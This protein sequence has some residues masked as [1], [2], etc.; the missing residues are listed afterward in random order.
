[1]ENKISIVIPV[2]NVVKYLQDCVNSLLCQT[3][4]N[5]E[6]ILVDDGSTDGSAA[7]C[8][9]LRE[10]D[11]RIVVVHQK[12]SGVSSARNKGIEV[13]TGQF[14]MFM[15]SDDWLDKNA[16]EGLLV[17][18]LKHQADVCFA[19]KYYK[20]ETNLLIATKYVKD[21]SEPTSIAIKLHLQHNFISSPCFSL[22]KN[23]KKVFFDQEIHI[24]EDWEYNFR[25]LV[26]LKSFI[27]YDKPFYHYRTVQA[28][29]SKS[30]VNS[31]KLSCFLIPEKVI[32][33]IEKNSLPFAEEAKYVSVFLTYMMLVN[34]TSAGVQKK[35]DFQ[36]LKKQARSILIYTLFSPL[37]SF[38]N[39]VS[40]LSG[41]ISPKLFALLF[42]R[43]YGKK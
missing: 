24:M 18:L 25:L 21:F 40:I 42:T 33:F 12:N 4:Q 16:L 3:Y 28:S 8:D 11:A 9:K 37:A 5:F 32:N 17:Q 27:M 20:D 19:N 2:Y 35:E 41:A 38:N 15:D 31:R 13:S 43:K 36:T 23:T 1:M 29:A 10:G 34:Y 14:I 6:I 7:L 30:P 22:A 39:K 26:S